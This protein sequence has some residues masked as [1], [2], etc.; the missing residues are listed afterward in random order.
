MCLV[1]G[2]SNVKIYDEKAI[3]VSVDIDTA[4]REVDERY[5]SFA[6]GATLIEKRW[7][8]FDGR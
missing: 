4:V 8:N 6:I 3:S 2:V 5:S 1:H 7:M